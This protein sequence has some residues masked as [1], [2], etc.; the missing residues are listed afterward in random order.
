VMAAPSSANA[1]SID[2]TVNSSFVSVSDMMSSFS[3]ELV[4]LT[5]NVFHH[6]VRFLACRTLASQL[7]GIGDDFR[8][9]LRAEAA[10]R[11]Q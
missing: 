4:R 6:V 7:A 3:E 11:C 2:S 8:N 1:E 5:R 10:W 9:R